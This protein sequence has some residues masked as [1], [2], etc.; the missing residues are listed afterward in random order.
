MPLVHDLSG[1]PPSEALPDPRSIRD[2]VDF[3][4]ET[5]KLHPDDPGAIVSVVSLAWRDPDTGAIFAGAWPFGQGGDQRPKFE[6]NP[7]DLGPDEY[8]WLLDWL[9]R[10]GGGLCGHNVVFDMQFLALQH[11]DGYATRDLSA[12]FRWDTMVAAQEL[13]PTLPSHGLKPLSVR[14]FDEDADAEQQALKP[15]LGPKTDARYDRVPWSVMH[16]YALKDAIYTNQLRWLQ[17]EQLAEGLVNGRHLG[18]QLALTRAILDMQLLGMPYDPAWSRQIR[19]HLDA[20]IARLA[21]TLPF[22]PTGPAAVQ[23]F[24]FADE[25]PKLKPYG[26]TG[27]GKPSLT[28]DIVE[29]MAAD[30]VE[31]ADTWRTIGRYKSAVSKWYGPFADLAGPDLRIR[32]SLRQNHVKSGRLSASRVN[33]QA[34]PQ[35]YK[36]ELPVPTPRELIGHAVAVRHPGWELWDLDLQQAELRI[37]SMYARC[38]PMLQMVVEDR[39]AHGETATR[40]FGTT[41]EDPDFAF[42]RQ[43]AKRALQ[44]DTPVLTPKGW[45]P[46]GNISVGDQV[47]GADGR[48]IDVLGIP[49]EGES[50]LWEVTTKSGI[51][52]ECDAE[53]Q[54]TV[55]TRYGVRTLTTDELAARQNWRLSLVKFEDLDGPDVDLPLHPYILGAMLGDGSSYQ[56]GGGAPRLHSLISDRYIADRCGQLSGDQVRAAKVVGRENMGRFHFLGARILNGLDACGLLGVKGKNKFVPDQYLHASRN[57]RLELLRG[58]MDTDGCVTRDGKANIFSNTSWELVQ[59]V[60]GLVRSLGGVATISPMH[61]REDWSSAWFVHIRTNDCPF[62][63]PRKA[64]LWTP[65]KI[66]D[67]VSARPIHKRGRVRCLTVDSPDGL[68]VTRDY[69]VT[70]NCNFSLI[71]GSGPDTFREMVLRESGIDLGQAEAKRIVYSWRDLYPEFG[72]AIQVHMDLVDRTGYVALPNGRRRYY[73]KHEDS[74]S[75]FNQLVQTMQAEFTKEW[76]IYTNRLLRPYR[77]RGGGLLLMVHDSLEMLLPAAEA[78]GLVEQI[79][80]FGRD[81]WAQFFP[82]VPGGIDAARWDTRPVESVTVS[83]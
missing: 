65:N 27:A 5:S 51:R 54:W 19:D 55:D 72:A 33:L 20:E 76:L 22:R 41:P 18:T 21:A 47:I 34:V 6:D 12:R 78:P 69:A 31:H 46:I 39:D 2:L 68:F 71:F 7:V 74:H 35:D 37:A 64:E 75:A 48:A 70:H 1:R 32:S 9:S 23:W 17:A 67:S 4:C 14:F 10:A 50:D 77:S 16:P 3:D 29:R 63:L 8:E 44:V 82:G 43:I 58:L 24:F 40:L 73:A 66:R 11:R 36:I 53:H 26:L 52:I 60:S 57:Q 61:R 30:G 28:A 79:Q 38:E 49:Y 59:A 81:K 13:W 15:Y 83:R 45:V 42:N 80:R 62:S 25:G 56:R